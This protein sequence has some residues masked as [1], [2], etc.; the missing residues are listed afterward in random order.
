LDELSVR[1]FRC[2]YCGRPG[3]HG[4]TVAK[5]VGWFRIQQIYTNVLI[6]KCKK[7]AKICRVQMIGSVLEWADMSK[8][9]QSLSKE[10]FRKEYSKT[11]LREDKK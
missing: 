4:H 8:A 10:K 11:K 3:A 1:Y 9:E 7:C 5:T 2:P 6:L